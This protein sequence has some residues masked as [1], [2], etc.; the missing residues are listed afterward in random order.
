LAALDAINRQYPQHARAAKEVAR[1][2][3]DAD[4]VLPRLLEVACG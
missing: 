4:R 3:F 2:H 1:E